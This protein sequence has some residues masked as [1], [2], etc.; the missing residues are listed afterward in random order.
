[1]GKN[2][3]LFWLKEDFRFKK[4]LA[5]MEATKIMIKSSFFIFTK[6]INLKSK[7]LKNGG[8]RNL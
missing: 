4:N 3:G 2:I 5:L 6:K 7:K 1:M 8:L